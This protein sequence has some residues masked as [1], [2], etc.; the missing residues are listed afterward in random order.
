MKKGLINEAFR[1][2][3]LAGIAPINEIDEA[4]ASGHTKKV[5]F[6]FFDSDVENTARK[7]QKLGFDIELD[8]REEGDEG[9][10]DIETYYAGLDLTD[11]DMMNIRAILDDCERMGLQV[12]VQIGEEIYDSVKDAQKIDSLIAQNPELI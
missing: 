12:A 9:E 4:D 3:Q 2:Q 7:F 5:I 1:L 8:R 10:D 11:F 6:S